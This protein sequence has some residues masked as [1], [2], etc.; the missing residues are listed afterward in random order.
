[1]ATVRQLMILLE[2]AGVAIPKKASK[3]ALQ[4]LWESLGKP[5][6]PID[7]A[8]V[9][10]MGPEDEEEVYAPLFG[11]FVMHE[12]GTY[13]RVW[14]DDAVHGIYDYSPFGKLGL[15]DYFDG[16]EERLAGHFRIEPA[17]ER[18]MA[19]MHMRQTIVE[20]WHKDRS[21]QHKPNESGPEW[22]FDA[23]V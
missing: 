6:V 13:G 7:E 14:G 10:P 18:C 19:L 23:L 11:D 8:Y 17:D 20:T 3:A 15:P 21:A 12:D 9:T 5:L 2:N 22:A 1:M 16:R 4:G